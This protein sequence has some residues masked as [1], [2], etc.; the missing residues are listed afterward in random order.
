MPLVV[1]SVALAL[2]A[3][4]TACAEMEPAPAPAPA[5]PAA[6]LQPPALPSRKPAWKPTTPRSEDVGAVP[7]PE[8]VG[9]V[10]APLTEASVVL[11][12]APLATESP[13]PAVTPA[14]TPALSPGAT[15][16]GLRLTLRLPRK[17]PVTEEAILLPIEAKLSNIG[18]REARLTAATPCDVA[19]W[20]I[21][22][23]SGAALLAKEAAICAQVLAESSLKPGETLITRDQIEIPPHLLGAGSYRLRYVFWG[24]AAEETV[25]VR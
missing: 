13:P 2:L 22:D 25:D 10:S 9:A 3:A 15:A 1:R 20:Q 17:L 14:S 21:S 19:V 16:P 24:T 4:V 5:A 7:A 18:T 11:P 12:A 8:P 6:S 23:A